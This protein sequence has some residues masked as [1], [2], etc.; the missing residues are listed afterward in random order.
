MRG[1]KST[2][3]WHKVC[4]LL[5]GMEAAYDD[6]VEAMGFP[7]FAPVIEARVSVSSAHSRAQQAGAPTSS[8]PVS[9]EQLSP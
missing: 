1:S 6:I 2:G 4:F 9:E 5:G 3:F 8:S 7:R